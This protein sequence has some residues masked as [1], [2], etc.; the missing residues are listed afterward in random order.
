MSAL[1]PT[2][3][4]GAAH[5]QTYRH[6]P[7]GSALG[8]SRS[9]A[10]TRHIRPS[11]SQ[12]PRPRFGIAGLPARCLKSELSVASGFSRSSVVYTA[13]GYLCRRRH[14]QA[15][16]PLWFGRTLTQ[17]II[18]MEPSKISSDHFRIGVL[19]YAFEKA[20]KASTIPISQRVHGPSNHIC[21][22]ASRFLS[23]NKFAQ[24]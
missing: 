22:E 18:T 15:V 11:C 10:Q 4:A 14:R 17:Y 7:F 2:S 12:P 1:A 16:K 21:C 19:R 23:T 3:I 9:S 8:S 5:I 13:A 24:I 6:C 20:V